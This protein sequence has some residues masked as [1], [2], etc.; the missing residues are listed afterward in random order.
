MTSQACHPIP[1]L[2]HI[3]YHTGADVL[4]IIVVLSCRA[5]CRFYVVGVM[6][7]IA[8]CYRCRLVNVLVWYLWARLF[9]AVSITLLLS[10][11]MSSTLSYAGALSSFLR[12]VCRL[13]C[14]S[15]SLGHCF[16][17][18]S[19]VY[20]GLRCRQVIVLTWSC[21]LRGSTLSP[22]HYSCV[23]FVVYVVH[24][25]CPFETTHV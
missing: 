12:R 13:R 21:R 19:I 22:S 4:V 17:V 5:L 9:Y 3:L 14:S 20:V 24:L 1:Y 7:L 10:S 15:R 16:C 2:Y 11:C 25:Y 18:V 6:P 23:A 8:I